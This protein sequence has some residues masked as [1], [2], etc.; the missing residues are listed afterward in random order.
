MITLRRVATALSVC[1]FA[2]LLGGCQPYPPLPKPPIPIKVAEHGLS[3]VPETDEQIARR[4]ASQHQVSTT[5]ASESD[6]YLVCPT[7]FGCFLYGPDGPESRFAIDFNTDVERQGFYANYDALRRPT[8][9]VSWRTRCHCTGV[10][11][12]YQGER[13]FVVSKATFEIVPTPAP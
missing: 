9:G 8:G 7:H 1:G 11:W 6:L 3:P 10:M 2:M 12:T 13:R 4:S 5:G